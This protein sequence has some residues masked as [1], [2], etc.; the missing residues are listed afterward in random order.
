M[1]LSDDVTLLA[2]LHAESHI[3]GIGSQD[4]G[5]LD[6]EQGR[7]GDDPAVLR[8]ELDAELLG[9]AEARHEWIAGEIGACVGDEGF[10][11]ADIRREPAGHEH[12]RADLA[13]YLIVGGAD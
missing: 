11:V 12:Q 3:D 2:G 8:F 1:T 4:V 5:L 10:A 13:R 7:A 6:L 9:L